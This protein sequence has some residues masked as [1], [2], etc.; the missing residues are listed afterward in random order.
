MAE[1]IVIIFALP[2]RFNSCTQ[3]FENIKLKE[4]F[5]FHNKIILRLTNIDCKNTPR[6]MSYLKSRP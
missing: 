4:P 1:G 3:L 6:G 2:D 5:A